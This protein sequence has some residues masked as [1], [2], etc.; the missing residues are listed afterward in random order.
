[1]KPT[2][3]KRLT[4]GDILASHMLGPLTYLY[5]GVAEGEA[6]AERHAKRH[7]RRIDTALTRRAKAATKAERERCLCAIR[8]LRVQLIA[9]AKTGVCTG[10][11]YALELAEG[12][13]RCGSEFDKGLSDAPSVRGGTR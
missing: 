8:H 2:A 13:V 4:A 10:W 3:R 11:R 1:M 9:S 12:Y 6:A 5:S 7:A